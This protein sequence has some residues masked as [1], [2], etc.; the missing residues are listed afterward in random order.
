M[1]T[2]FLRVKKCLFLL[3]CCFGLLRTLLC[4]SLLCGFGCFLSG[5]FGSL[6]C[7][8]FSSL[9]GGLSLLG[10][11]GLF[12]GL[13]LLGRLGLLG[14][15]FLSHLLLGRLFG[16][17]LLNDLLLGFLNLGEFVRSLDGNE[18]L[19]CNPVAAGFLATFFL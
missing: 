13:G 16:G 14:G 18:G 9:F 19:L 11:L 7:C 15:G 8:G 3:G 12:G 1:D 6:L 10:R 2:I 17:L 4:C 5:G